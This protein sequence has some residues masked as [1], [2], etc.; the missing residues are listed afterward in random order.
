MFIWDGG[1]KLARADLAVDFARRQ[2]RAFVSHAHADHIARHE[3]TFCTP[4]TARLIE[5]RL[6]RRRF[7]EMSYRE[8]IEWGGLQLTAYPAGHCLGSAM[9]LAEDG[10]ESLLYTGDFKLGR[11]ATAVQAEL[12]RA[13]LLV[14]ESTYGRPQYRLPPRE[15]AVA[16][17]V[18]LVRRTLRDG[19]I[20]VVHAYILGKSQEV[21]RVLTDHGIAVVQHRHIHRVSQVY[22]QC[23]VGLGAF[24]LLGDQPPAN[25]AVVAPPRW[26]PGEHWPR[27][28]RI[29]V[30]GWAMASATRFRWSVDHAV[31]LSDHA[32][33]D[34]LIEA[35][36]R[37]GP[38]T[39]YCTHGPESF[40]DH[41][42]E[43]GFDARPLG[44]PWQRRLFN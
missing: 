11:S 20:P 16:E 24:G 36:E 14:I 28:V 32:D 39:V 37:V 22:E 44:R 15:Q 38:R 3:Y 26:R 23:G 31:P 41:L 35:V 40:V 4:G 19:A 1:L 17:L 13:D 43:R 29:A 21:T 12:P 8:P 5:L 6:G 34:E 27:A 25:T 30:T 9:L 7:L 10:A 33:F 18:E 42:A 2:P